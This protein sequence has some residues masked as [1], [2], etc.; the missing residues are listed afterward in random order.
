MSIKTVFSLLVVILCTAVS[1]NAQLPHFPFPFPFPNLFQPSPGVPGIPGFPFPFPNPFQPSP[2]MPGIPKFPFLFPNP[3]QPSPGMPVIPK[4]PFP[5]P[6]PFQPSPGMPGIPKFPFPFPNPFPPSPS[7]PGI[8]QPSQAM[9]RMQDIVVTKCWST[10]MN[11]P[12]CFAEMR[13]AV[14]TDKFSSIGPVCCKDFLDVEANCTPNLP[15]NLFFPPMLKQQC[16]K[17][18]GPPTTAP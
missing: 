7:I 18:A 13:Q 9:P 12:G 17:S 15:I 3:F 4:F 16:V 11:M 2:G 6:N 10:V 8:L 14:M 5:F 1:V